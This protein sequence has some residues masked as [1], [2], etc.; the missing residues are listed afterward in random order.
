MDADTMIERTADRHGAGPGSAGPYVS[1]A[2]YRL[3][4]A[5]DPQTALARAVELCAR[6]EAF[7]ARGFGHWA[8]VLIGQ[9]NRGQ[10]RFAVRAAAAGRPASVAG[11]VGWFRAGEAEAERW[12]AGEAAAHDPAGDCVVLNALV[13]EEPGVLRAVLAHARTLEAAPYVLYARRAYAGGRTRPVRLRVPA[14]AGTDDGV[15]NF[16]CPAEGVARRAAP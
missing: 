3:L 12:L 14:R 8:R 9:I 2:P 5:R 10:Y 7:A 13:A 4:R 15:C 6:H 1:R 16:G 11:F